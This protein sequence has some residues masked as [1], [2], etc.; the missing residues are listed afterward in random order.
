MEIL[1]FVLLI[2]GAVVGYGAR[3]ILEKVLKRDV[4]DKEAGIWKS[5]G[6]IA[7]FA[8]AVIIFIIKK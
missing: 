8:G 2:A 1:A 7:A 6:L 4:T 3:P 5:V